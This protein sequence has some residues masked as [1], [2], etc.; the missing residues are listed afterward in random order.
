MFI[1]R[2]TVRVTAGAGG[3][4]ICSFRREKFAAMGGPDGGDGGKGGDIIVRGESNLAT[5]LDFTYR[6]QWEAERGDHGSGSNK[7][8]H[9]GADVTL[10]VPPGTVIRNHDTG[11]IIAEVLEDGD[12][13]LRLGG[14]LAE[15]REA[16]EVLGMRA[17][18]EVEAR[19]VHAGVD[20]RLERLHRIDRWTER[21]DELRTSYRHVSPRAGAS[22]EEPA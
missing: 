11:E 12:G 16:L 20:Q 13:L 4:G 6:N 2:V 7:T 3:S 10:P 9:S 18:R 22:D 5:L 21:A 8:G 17:V 1:D 15:A 19:D 14:C